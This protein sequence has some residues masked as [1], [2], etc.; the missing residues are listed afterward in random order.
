[1]KEGSVDIFLQQ[2][3][4]RL[5]EQDIKDFFEGVQKTPGG[6]GDNDNLGDALHLPYDQSFEIPKD[7]FTIGTF[8]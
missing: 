4:D 7:G 8:N 2:V 1:M 6:K 3:I 5:S